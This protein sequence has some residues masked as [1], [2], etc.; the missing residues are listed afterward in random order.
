MCTILAEK[1]KKLDKR[2]A[3]QKYIIFDYYF[4]RPNLTQRISEITLFKTYHK[5]NKTMQHTNTM[6]R[7]IE[8]YAYAY[9]Q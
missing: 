2:L 5:P 4:I 9:S 6:N 8:D 7:V 1:L 3:R